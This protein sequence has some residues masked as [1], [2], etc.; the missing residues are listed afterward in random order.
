MKKNNLTKSFL[1]T[2][3]IHRDLKP[4]NFLLV[5]GRLKLIDFGIAS[6]IQTEQTSIL[7]DTQ[8]GTF[9]YM[10]PEA[11]K[12]PAPGTGHGQKVSFL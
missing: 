4:A 11:L 8:S 6:A 9:N 10:S 5:S 12:C 3:I 2:D 1:C 7:T